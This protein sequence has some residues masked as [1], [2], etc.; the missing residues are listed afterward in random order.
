MNDWLYNSLGSQGM[1]IYGSTVTREFDIYTMELTTSVNFSK[2][3]PVIDERESASSE[4]RSVA[5]ITGVKV[6][7]Y[8]PKATTPPCPASSLRPGILQVM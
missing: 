4:W 1:V 3:T 5:N 8:E 6:G 2:P 7:G